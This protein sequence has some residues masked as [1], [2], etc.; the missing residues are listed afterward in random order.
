MDGTE[1]GDEEEEVPGRASMAGW[2][3]CGAIHGNKGSRW[4]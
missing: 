1:R 4:F 2:D 3:I